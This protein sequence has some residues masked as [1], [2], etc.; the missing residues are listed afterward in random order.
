[1]ILSVAVRIDHDK[2]GEGAIQARP[3]KHGP[4]DVPMNPCDRDQQRQSSAAH[5]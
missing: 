5:I 3:A 2:R 1:M 4:W